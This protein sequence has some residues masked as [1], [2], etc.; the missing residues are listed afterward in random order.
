MTLI[1]PLS[2]SQAADAKRFGPKAARLAALGHAG[3]PTPGGFCVDA[4]AYRLQLA[5]LGLEEAARGVFSAEDRPQ[6]RRHALS[7]KTP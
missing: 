2:H 3:L 1:L 5:H 6:A 7:V 4:Q